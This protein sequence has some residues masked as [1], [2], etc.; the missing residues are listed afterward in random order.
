MR[1]VY[2]ATSAVFIGFSLYVLFEAR[3]MNYMTRIGPGAGFFPTWLGLALGGLSLVWLVQVSVRP[4]ETMPADFVPDRA[5]ILRVLA[6]TGALILYTALV[7]QTG[8][9]LTTFVFLLFLLRMLGRQRLPLVL[10]VS[11]LGSFGVY[12]VF[13]NWLGVLLPTASIGWLQDLG[14]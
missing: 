11:I 3:S 8:Y 6:I 10:I 7:G 9:Q 5:G 12:V 13:A 2:Q 4:V 1:R 14:L